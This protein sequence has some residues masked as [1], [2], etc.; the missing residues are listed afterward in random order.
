MTDHEVGQPTPVIARSN[1]SYTDTLGNSGP[2]TAGDV[3]VTDPPPAKPVMRE[4]R[5]SR[6]RS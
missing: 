5:M 6:V 2:S 4:L 3:Y 1:F